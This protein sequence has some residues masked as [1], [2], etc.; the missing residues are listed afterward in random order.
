VQQGEGID[1]PLFCEFLQEKY[2][3]PHILKP[4]P[5][6]SREVRSPRLEIKKAM[7]IDE[8]VEEAEAD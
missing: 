5:L 4:R 3:R 1:C 6:K 8:N 2:N 7:V